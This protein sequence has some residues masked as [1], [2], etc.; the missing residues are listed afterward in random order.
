MQHTTESSNDAAFQRYSRRALVAPILVTVIVLVFLQTTPVSNLW[1]SDSEVLIRSGANYGP[2]TL[3]GQWWRLFTATFLHGG[4]LHLAFNAWMLWQIGVF[5]ERLLGKFE[6]LIVYVA[7]GIFGSLASVWFH[8]LSVCV[9][10]SGAVF[11]LLGALFA[12]LLCRRDTISHTAFLKLRN[13]GL[14]FLAYNIA[15]GFFVESVDLAGHVGG[16][17]GGFACGLVLVN[18]NRESIARR[19]IRLHVAA[20]GVALALI[21][22]IGALPEAPPNFYQEISRF[23][24]V[25]QLCL[26]E[27]RSATDRHAAHQI[28]KRAFLEIVENDVLNPWREAKVGITSMNHIPKPQAD[29]IS[30]LRSY[31]DARQGSWECLLLAIRNAD[32][33]QLA[34]YHERWNAADQIARELSQPEN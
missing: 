26:N 30:K 27:Y 33:Q 29:Y 7:S 17:A 10:A 11:G 1:T 21:F 32:Q 18:G 24:E 6:F 20:A 25:E 28:S 34:L 23:K 13:N 31:V 12:Y 4:I 19:A 14:A 9:G 16:L 5:I 3:E 8:S 15:L 22:A 2:Y